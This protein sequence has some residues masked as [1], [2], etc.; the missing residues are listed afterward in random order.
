MFQWATEAKQSL[1]TSCGVCD[2]ARNLLR[3]DFEA[4][5]V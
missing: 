1:R 4:R 5:R 2:N 3:I